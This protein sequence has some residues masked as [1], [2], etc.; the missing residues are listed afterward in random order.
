ML[1]RSTD[2]NRFISRKWKHSRVPLFL[3][4]VYSALLPFD[5]IL[6]MGKIGTFTRYVAMALICALWADRLLVGNFKVLRPP[7]ATWSWFIYV[8]LAVASSQWALYPEVTFS[9]LFT[10][11]GLF[12][13]YFSV[14]VFPS[15]MRDYSRIITYVIL[16][17]VVAAI[18]VII[19]YAYGI[20]FF[21][22]ERGSLVVGEERWA[23][24]NYF[25]T[26]LILPI[27]LLLGQMER[28]STLSGWIGFSAMVLAMLLT[29][30]RGA[31]VGLVA[32][33]LV[34]FYYNRSRQRVLL[35]LVAGFTLLAVAST[36]MVW[37]LVPDPLAFLNRFKFG[38]WIET[39]GSGRLHVWQVGWR[40]FLDRPLLGYGYENFPYAYEAYR[41]E[42]PQTIYYFTRPLRAAHS[43]YI[44]TIIELGPLGFLT[45]LIAIFQHWKILRGLSTVEV[46]SLQAAFVGILV[47]TAFLSA[48][49]FKT[50]WL[51]FTLIVL[52]R[53]ARRVVTCAEKHQ[54][55][56]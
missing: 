9:S 44:A 20:T 22:T 1:H 33:M 18:W 30:S 26:S 38:T 53:N 40:A 2:A 54:Q 19:S 8:A 35:R 27:T 3:L 50:F 24:P 25:G 13:V 32:A 7:A 6:G 21:G 34:I 45:L 31:M 48:S 43:V 37:L 46:R 15:C 14:A 56:N 28:K 41:G 55:V 42:F 16:G 5:Q 29:G 52:V 51:V 12:L 17:G 47:A 49:G 23:D 10:L 39:G 4:A 11:V 36:A